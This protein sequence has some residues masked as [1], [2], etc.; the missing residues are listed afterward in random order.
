MNLFKRAWWRLTGQLGKT[1]MLIGLFTVICTL[2]LSGFLIQSA[3]AR[4]ADDAKRKV[5]VV[6]TM[7]LDINAL[8]NSGGTNAGGG[9]RPSTIGS[10]GELRSSLVDKICASSAVTGCN[11]AVGS[12]G[13]PGT[14]LKLHQPVPTPPGQ[15]AEGTDFFSASGILD[16]NQE[17]DFR[18][19][20]SKIIS[21]R[22]ITPTSAKDEIVIEERVANDNKIK[23]G[24]VVKLKVGEI[25]MDGKQRSD[26]DLSFK[27][28]GI[29]KN[30]TADTGAYVPAMMDPA[31]KIYTTPLG[32]SLLLGKDGSDGILKSA[33][34]SLK[35]PDD[36]DRLKKD[37]A[38]AGVDPKIFPLTVND[39]QY[40]A[41]V[42]P[43]TR[44]A[45]FASLT[46]WLVALAGTAILALIIAS[47]LR[48]RRKE[49]G[50]LLALGEKKPLLLGQHLVEIFACALIA[51]GIASA[52]SQALA[53][54]IG[55][56][57]LAGEV[58]SAKDDAGRRTPE[59]DYS[60][61]G[62]GT[63]DDGPQV[64]PI[65]SLEVKVGPSDI[66]Q[67]GVLGLGIAAIAT[68]LPGIRVMRMSPRDI[69]TKG[70]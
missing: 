63:K 37:A 33:T 3:A 32:S 48:E 59:Q 47:A 27:V 34:F 38:A 16:L 9:G 70:D 7:Q 5:G 60:S 69:L 10:K 43:I 67:V 29:Y 18:N 25:P 1:A 44:T 40:Q 55:D 12:V 23:V 8:I 65:D 22:G 21:G 30:S 46:V 58:S 54:P 31:N 57:L 35:N 53:Q 19:G 20:D 13:R 41:L 24:D 64:D 45:G 36:L 39:K 51:I 15:N 42:G 28:V 17:K 2:V 61:I 62:G 6:A 50:I 68:V 56:G 11:Y 4:A 52:A 66:A 49:L 14:G 26:A